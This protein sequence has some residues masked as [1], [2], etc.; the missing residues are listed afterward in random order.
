MKH[1]IEEY[2]L[3]GIY[4]MIGFLIVGFM[5]AFFFLI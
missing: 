1:L 4:I 3:S 5:T 2:G